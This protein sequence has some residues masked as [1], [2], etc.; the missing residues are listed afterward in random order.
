M[1]TESGD[2]KLVGN[3]RKLIDQVSAEQNYNPANPKLTKTALETQYTTGEAAAD[4]VSAKH[5]PNKLAVTDRQGGFD[6]LPTLVIRSRNFLKAS[7]ASKAVVDDAETHVR[8]LTGGRKSAK[9]K[10]D[11]A[12]PADESKASHSASQ[13]S[14]DN[15]LGN[16]G[17]YLEILKNVPS[18][19]PNEADL[20]LTS[21]TAFAAN[22]KARNNAVSTTSAALNQAR[23]LRDRLLYLDDDSIANTA[24]MVKTYVKGA[25]GTS[26][27]LYKQIKGL[28][29]VKAAK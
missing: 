19:N 8:K 9:V 12:T 1:P 4:D 23:G 20:K 29:F 16:L 13:M 24:Q 10:D 11:P 14:Y 5:A 28:Q 22:L 26:S 21:L 6:D 18:Y 2:K 25:L 15:Q 3:F 17:A 27:Q 7:G